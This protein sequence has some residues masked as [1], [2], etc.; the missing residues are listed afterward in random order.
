MSF[1]LLNVLQFIL[2]LQKSKRSDVED[3]NDEDMIF[4]LGGSLRDVERKTKISKKS[5]APSV[6]EDMLDSMIYNEGL[7]GFR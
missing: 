6:P 5:I 3:E 2:F 4:M 7:L 1:D